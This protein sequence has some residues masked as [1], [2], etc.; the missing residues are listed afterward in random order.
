MKKFS[1]AVGAAI[2]LASVTAPAQAQTLATRQLGA[3][4]NTTGIDES[5]YGNQM[6]GM[7]VSVRFED[8]TSPD[9]IREAFGFWSNLSGSS[10]G[11]DLYYNSTLY[12][13]VRLG[14]A[15]NTF[16]SDWTFD[17]FSSKDF[18]S[19][20]FEG[21]AQYGNVLFDIGTQRCNTPSLTCAG[22]TAPSSTGNEF[23]IEFDDEIDDFADDAGRGT[24]TYSNA[25]SY[26]GTFQY[27]IF[28]TVEMV[29][30]TTS[31]GPDKDETPFKFQMDTDKGVFESSPNIQTTVPEP[32]TYAL[33][34][35]GLMGIFGFA[36]RRNRNA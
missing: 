9:V 21:G 12:G 33:M 22:N 4:S 23:D 24:V 15:S 16:N 3:V 26:L 31:Y 28:T 7:R 8:S 2:A 6:S 32:S 19:L 14:D 13:S 18:R 34:G 35:A 27:D 17:W 25:V 1:M 5:I 11:V 30:P 29:F 20:K 36:R 10:S